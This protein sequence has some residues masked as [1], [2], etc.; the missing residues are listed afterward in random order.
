VNGGPV[1]ATQ[2]RGMHLLEQGSVVEG[3]PRDTVP[4]TVQATGLRPAQGRV[5]TTLEGGAML[6]RLSGGWFEG[7]GPF[8]CRFFERVDCRH[9]KLHS[10]FLAFF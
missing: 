6:A 10:V 9:G 1:R 8:L 3:V 2:C 4:P 7:G 5:C